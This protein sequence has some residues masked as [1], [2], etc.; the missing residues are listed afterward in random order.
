MEREYGEAYSP[1]CDT[2]CHAF[3]NRGEW[4]STHSRSTSRQSL[5]VFTGFK[6]PRHAKSPQRPNPN[7]FSV[8]WIIHI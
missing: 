5:S 8:P 7:A 3:P 6:A 4:S 1:R 2:A